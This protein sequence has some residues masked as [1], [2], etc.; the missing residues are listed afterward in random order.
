MTR[1]IAITATSV[2]P[3][4]EM[5][6]NIASS[7]LYER[8]PWELFDIIRTTISRLERSLTA[9][10]HVLVGIHRRRLNYTL[11]PVERHVVLITSYQ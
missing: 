7:C 8:H 11:H 4:I 6:A 10:E 3:L 5:S 2:L 9:D 1:M